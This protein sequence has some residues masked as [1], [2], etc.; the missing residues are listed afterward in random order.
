MSGGGEVIINE[1]T[2]IENENKF[3]IF[4]DNFWK[5]GSISLKIIISNFSR[6]LLN[7]GCFEFN[8]RGIM[9]S[10]FAVRKVFLLFL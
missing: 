4:F 2:L 5:V 7:P 8:A 9:K 1:L 3:Q 6:M 10:A